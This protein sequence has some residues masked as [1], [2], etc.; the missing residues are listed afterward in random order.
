MKLKQARLRK[1]SDNCSDI[2]QVALGSI[3]VPF[4]FDRF[5]IWMLILGLLTSFT[6]WL[7]SYYL[8]R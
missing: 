4:A 2:A 5:D 1:L 6:F 3:V 7:L 8:A